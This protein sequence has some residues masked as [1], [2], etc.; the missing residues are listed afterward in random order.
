MGPEE[1]LVGAA[2]VLLPARRILAFT[3]AGISTESGIPDFRG[4]NGL[5]TKVDPED[6]SIDRYLGCRDVRVRRWRMHQTGELWGA[7]STV[8]PN[9]AHDAVTRLAAM[10]RLVG[11]VTQNIDGLHQAAGLA[12]HLVAEVHGNVRKAAC[13]RCGACWPTETVLARVD[14][15]EDDPHCPN[16]GGLVKPTTVLFGEVLPNDQIDRALGFAMDADAVLA[17]GTTMSVYPAVDFALIAVGR[18]CPMVIINLGATE[19]D[20]RA[21]IR[22]DAKAGEALPALVDLLAG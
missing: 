5:W 1:A 16:C 20:H 22:I 11:C 12:D 2:S 8:Q 17:I 15:G 14:A 9:P 18:G 3:G 6:F 10:G 4:P 13:V 19:H 7:R 21:T